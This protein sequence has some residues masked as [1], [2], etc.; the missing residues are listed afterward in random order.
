MRRVALLGT[1][2]AVL[3]LAVPL[4]TQA[5]GTTSHKQA[6]AQRQHVATTGSVHRPQ[7]HASTKKHMT[8]QHRRATQSNPTMQHPG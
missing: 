7:R 8:T 2:T 4:A 3:F 5:A 1:L 6:M